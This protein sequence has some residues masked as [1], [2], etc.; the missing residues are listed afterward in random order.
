MTDLIVS[1]FLIGAFAAIAYGGWRITRIDRWH[2]A[3]RY[4]VGLPLLIGGGLFALVG[5]SET[6]DP[7]DPNDQTHKVAKSDLDKPPRTNPPKSD[8]GEQISQKPKA[9]PTVSEPEPTPSEAV[10]KEP[11]APILS[12]PQRNALRSARSYISMQGFSRKG[13]IEQ[14]SSEYGEGYEVADATIAVD[15]LDVDWNEQASRSAQSYLDMMGFSC[16]GLIEQLSSSAGEKFTKS[17]ARYGAQQA[18]A[19]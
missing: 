19:C 16:Q 7:T 15:S 8:A 6:I 3:A 1:V 10:A 17:E 13:L 4:I 5:L 9:E 11:Q 2:K 12:G 18:G 14:L